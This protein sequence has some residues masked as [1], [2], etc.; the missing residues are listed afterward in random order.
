[1][2]VVIQDSKGNFSFL[3]STAW[4]KF[5][6]AV[7]DRP[8]KIVLHYSGPPV[9]SWITVKNFLISFRWQFFSCREN[10]ACLLFIN[11]MYSIAVKSLTGKY[12]AGDEKVHVL[13]IQSQV[14]WLGS[15]GPTIGRV[16]WYT[17]KNNI[18][19]RYLLSKREVGGLHF[20]TLVFNKQRS[21]F[22]LSSFWTSVQILQHIIINIG[23]FFSNFFVLM[24]EN[25]S[26]SCSIFFF[27]WISQWLKNVL[28]FSSNK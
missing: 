14:C 23:F 13:H 3:A 7:Q 17:V 15:Q 12:A 26:A 19:L 25:R 11:Y 16:D 6:W 4:R 10:R 9:L 27:G 18:F 8:D 20:L 2:S 5:P 1:M 28:L 21:K 24:N 22:T